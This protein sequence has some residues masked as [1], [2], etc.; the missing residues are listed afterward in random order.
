MSSHPSHLLRI[1]RASLDL[2]QIAQVL[3]LEKLKTITEKYQLLG[4]IA[5]FFKNFSEAQT[6]FTRSSNPR[7]ALEMRRNLLHWDQALALAETL[8]PDDVPVLSKEYAQQLEFRGEFGQALE[9]YRRGKVPLPDVTGDDDG[10]SKAALQSTNDACA[11]GEARM[12]LRTGAIRNGCQA[13]LQT[14][15][16]ALCNECANILEQMKQWEE[17]AVLFE[18]SEQYEK[19]ARIQI[20]EIKNLKAAQKLLPK[21]KAKNILIMYAK[22]KETDGNYQDAENAYAQAE[23]WDNVVRLKVDHLNDIHS[24]HQIVRKTKSNDAAALVARSCVKLGEHKAAIEFLLMARKTNEAMD[25]AKKH[26]EMKTLGETL[27]E[28]AKSL[29]PGSGGMTF[30]DEYMGIAIWYEDVGDHE[31]AGDFF[32]LALQYPRA[33]AKYTQVGSESCL[34]KAIDVVAQAKNETLTHRMF[35]YLMGEVD[36]KPKDLNYIF[37]LY[38]ALHAYDKAARTAVI[39]SKQEQELGNYRVAHKMLFE[40]FCTLR[41]NNVRI[42]GELRRTLM[43]QH[44]YLIVRALVK[45]GD[46]EGSARMLLRVARNIQKFPKHV[47]PILTS[48]V[49]ECLKVDFKASAYE[50]ASVLVQPQYRSQI[51]EKHRKKVETTIRKKGKEEL[52]DPTERATPCPY[53]GALVPETTLDCHNCKNTIP[54]CIVTGRHMILEDWCSCPKCEF[55]ALFTF[56]VELVKTDEP[57]CPM[58]DVPLQPQDLV[59]RDKSDNKMVP[60][61]DDDKELTHMN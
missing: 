30:H 10:N 46:H 42:L 49:V 47:V 60:F 5:M 57:K 6:H 37:R 16:K 58:C 11:A 24:A 17:A 56:F 45:L 41:S 2:G 61:Q 19:A 55:P 43:L 28:H 50:Y 15:N 29:P 1:F 7:L 12:L 51:P 3:H 33:L 23:D 48:T 32:A 18:R 22:A 35:E 52:T 20:R 53:C 44:S 39:L 36:G 14:G 21:I 38:L 13:A 4:Y 26:N 31:S 40:T 59:R 25:I 54:F 8:S 9:M 34:K 27:I